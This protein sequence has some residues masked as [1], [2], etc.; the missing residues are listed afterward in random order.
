MNTALAIGFATTGVTLLVSIFLFSLDRFL[1]RRANARALRRELVARVLDTF[2][3]STRALLR[4]AFVQ[5]WT[6]GEV[7]FTLLTPRLLLDL[8]P[9]ERVIVGWMQRQ[10]Q[11]MQLSVARA[12][13]VRIRVEVAEALIRWHQGSRSLSWFAVELKKDPVVHGLIVPKSVRARQFVRD[14]WAWAQF[15][16][17]LAAIAFVLRRV[18]AS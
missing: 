5:A 3:Q 4:P 14:S 2:E 17:L 16:G 15:L 1:T 11:L 8:E 18:V 9:K 13:R 6:N 12:E 10:V 7:E